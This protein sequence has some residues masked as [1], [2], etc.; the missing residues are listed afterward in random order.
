M[1][2]ESIESPED[3]TRHIVQNFSPDLT[4]RVCISLSMQ[5]NLGNYENCHYSIRYE[6]NCRPE[7]RQALT[8]L[9]EGEASQWIAR[10][11]AKVDEFIRMKNEAQSKGEVR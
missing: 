10:K 8:E 11:S 3:M 9:L 2:H 5:R 6:Q 1:T 7:D 4:A